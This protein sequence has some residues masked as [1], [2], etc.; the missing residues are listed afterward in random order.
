MAAC[1]LHAICK[2]THGFY[3]CECKA[4]LTGKNPRIEDCKD[5]NECDN[6]KNCH[7]DAIC[8]NTFGSFHCH[9]KRG[10]KGDGR[11]KCVE[12]DRCTILSN[13]VKCSL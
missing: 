13:K 7:K 11:H 1:P 5:V 12:I 3:E 9:C 4:G 6:K 2:D 8:E 10:F